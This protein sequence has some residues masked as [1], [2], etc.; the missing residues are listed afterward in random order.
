MPKLSVERRSECVAKARKHAEEVNSCFPGIDAFPVKSTRRQLERYI[1]WWGTKEFDVSLTSRGLSRHGSWDEPAGLLATATQL[2]ALLERRKPVPPSGSVPVS[3]PATLPALGESPASPSGGPAAPKE[4][5][6]ITAND[7]AAPPTGAPRGSNKPFFTIEALPAGHGDCL[8]IEY[9]KGRTTH[10]VLIDCGT[11]AT[12]KPLIARVDAVPESE[13]FLELFVLSHIDSDHI[14]GALP[15]FNAVKRGLRFGDVWFNGWRHI[16]GQLGAM[17]G[18][19]FS[20]AILDFELPWNMWRAGASILTDGDTLPEHVLPGGMRLTL[21]SPT[22]QQLTKLA[23]IWTRELKR[24]GLTPGARVD[25]DKFL[26][27]RRPRSPT[28][29]RCRTSTV[30]PM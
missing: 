9:G 30:L 15:F 16:S 11:Q 4:A 24:Y 23:P 13:R 3:P 18:E 28:P 14:G 26:R 7:I 19:M 20:S 8:W 10:R 1:D 27:A 21:L 5:S 6:G 25:Y 29:Q 2:V 22:R 12:S 17:Q